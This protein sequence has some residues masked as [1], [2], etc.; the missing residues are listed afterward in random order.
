VSVAYWQNYRR[1]GADRLILI[2]IVETRAVLAEYQAAIPGAAI[3]LVRLQATLPTLH[4]RLRQREIGA[5]LTWHQQR[6][7]ELMMQMEREAVEDL[8]VDTEGKAITE[9]ARE[10]L[11]QTRWLQNIPRRN[12]SL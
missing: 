7:R 12:N 10:I 4:G 2:D 9:V 3:T 1:A 5:S 6:A 8:R 11:Q